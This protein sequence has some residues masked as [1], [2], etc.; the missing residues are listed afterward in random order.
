MGK[1]KVGDRLRRVS[2]AHL[3][4]ALGQE[5]VVTTPGMSR[6]NDVVWYKNKRGEKVWSSELNWELVHG[7]VRERTIKEV[8]EWNNGKLH[9]MPH[10]AGSVLIAVSTPG[11][12]SFASFTAEELTAAI[13]H[14]TAIRDALV[15][16][17]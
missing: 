4:G 17:E 2:G 16:E 7:P 6:L 5:V 15:S 11:D 12:V 1:F 13:N 14:L 9:V 10:E 3:D 8:V